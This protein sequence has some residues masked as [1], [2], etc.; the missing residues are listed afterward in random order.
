VSVHGSDDTS[1]SISAST[2]AAP[3]AD[4]SFRNYTPASS[5]PSMTLSRGGNE[6]ID[7]FIP[8]GIK[9]FILLCVNTGNLI[10]LANV[11][12]TD[13]TDSKEMFVRMRRAYYEIRGARAR[14]PLF[15][16]MTMQ[17]IKVN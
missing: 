7:I 2:N 9:K 1:S 15:Q 14:N 8:A 16:P 4:L 11:D 17:Y 5:P 10:K 13:L 12:V 6:Q 3:A